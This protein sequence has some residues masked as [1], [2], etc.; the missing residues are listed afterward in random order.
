MTTSDLF[1]KYNNKFKYKISFNTETSFNYYD[2]VGDDDKEDVKSVPKP[3]KPRNKKSTA[4]PIPVEKVAEPVEQPEQPE[5]PKAPEMTTI[6]IDVME[7][8]AEDTFEEIV[9]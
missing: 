9:T 3:R 5:T 7:M 8:N 1:E 4:E 2:D 6:N